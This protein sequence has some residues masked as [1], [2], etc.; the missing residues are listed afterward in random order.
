MVM[1]KFFIYFILGMQ[2][3]HFLWIRDVLQKDAGT[4]S[5][6]VTAA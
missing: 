3:W 1:I 2:T 4:V 5:I 6:V